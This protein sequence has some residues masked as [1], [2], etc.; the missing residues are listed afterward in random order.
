[1]EE[2]PDLPV[3]AQQHP[4]TLIDGEKLPHDTDD[5][6][7]QSDQSGVKILIL[8]CKLLHN[9]DDDG[10]GRC[11]QPRQDLVTKGR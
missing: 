5:S 4:Y 2:L 3:Q 9:A 8:G 1:M 7:G 10:L 6:G 11:Q